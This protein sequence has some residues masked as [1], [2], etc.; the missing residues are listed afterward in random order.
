M[1]NTKNR[2][3][4]AASAVGIHISIGSVY[5]WSNFTNPLIEEFGWT[6]KEVQFTFSLA[7]LF[8]GLS[9]AFLGHFVEKHGPEKPG[10]LQRAFSEQEF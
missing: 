2:W 1:K 8:L 10:Y 5:A 7:I 3:L 9:A 6:S 4:I